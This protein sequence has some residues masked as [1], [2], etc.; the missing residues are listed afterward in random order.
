[1]FQYDCPNCGSK[2]KLGQAAEPGQ[3]VRCPVCRTAFV[4][5]AEILGVVAED[6]PARAG[7]A[8]K[9]ARPAVKAAKPAAAKPAAAK[10]ATAKPAAPVRPNVVADD[11]L[12][13]DTTP[14]GVI[15]ESEEEQ[16]LIAKN[17]PKFT[18]VRDKFKKSAR[19][20][21]QALLVLP[22][23][24]LVAEGALTCIAGIAIIVIAIWPLIFTDAPPSDEDYAEAILYGFIG[25]VTFVWGGLVCYGTS[26]MQ[27]LESYAWA[28][29]GCILGVVPLLA[30][31]FGLVALRD[32]R[33]IAGFE[34]VEGAI[35]DEDEEEE[36]EEEED[37]EDDEDDEDEE[38][39]E[40]PRRKKKR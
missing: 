12:D 25:L 39:E 4:P 34:E 15:K 18:E 40:R 35:D 11:D 20:P 10:P 17:K 3:E 30:G 26:K 8:A 31:I 5:R 9:A 13:N 24:L 28:L 2:V 29:V 22:T 14:Y 7:R 6:P 27:A 36:E 33:V 16:R 19:G 37:D 21:A 38:E 1:M 23:N 32:P